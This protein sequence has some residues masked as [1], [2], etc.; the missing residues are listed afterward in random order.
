MGLPD[1]TPL[2][3]WGP[4]EFPHPERAPP[5]VGQGVARWLDSSPF[6]VAGVDCRPR[7]YGGFS[8]TTNPEVPERFAALRE[9]DGEA[10]EGQLPEGG[11]EAP[12]R[13]V[14]PELRA[15]MQ[16]ILFVPEVFEDR[17]VIYQRGARLYFVSTSS[18]QLWL[19]AQAD[20]SAEVLTLA[21]V[22]AAPPQGPDTR[23]PFEVQQAD[24]LV[25]SH[26]LGRWC[27]HPVPAELG[28][29]AEAI[30]E[31]AW[32]THGRRGLFGTHADTTAI[33]THL[34]RWPE[35]PR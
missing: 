20:P 32:L 18:G 3:R 33:S 11:V 2:Y 14:Y 15:D 26:V 21:S 8:V 35:E 24:F 4:V 22:W 16:G 5:V 27:P 34:E 10:Y 30:A 31:H 17:W 28:T 7:S 13:L 9:A 29:D 12:C 19:V 23:P 1:D 25:K 6:G